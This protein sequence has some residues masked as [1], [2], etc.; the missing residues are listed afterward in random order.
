MHFSF[1]RK[2]HQGTRQQHNI[3]E[4]ESEVGSPFEYQI[5]KCSERRFCRQTTSSRI[6]QSI[7]RQ[8]AG[9]RPINSMHL[10]TIVSAAPVTPLLCRHRHSTQHVNS[11]LVSLVLKESWATSA[12]R[13]VLIT[14]TE[15]GGLAEAHKKQVPLVRLHKFWTTKM[16][17]TQMIIPFFL[18]EWKF[19][20]I[21]W[22]IKTHIVSLA[23]LQRW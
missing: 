4:V 20:Y 14:P 3:Y 16:R 21:N 12:L 6:E 17:W 1:E 8:P 9:P 10:Y 23:F 15:R 2:A 18:F 22:L 5:Y 11:I 7:L 19:V 13:R